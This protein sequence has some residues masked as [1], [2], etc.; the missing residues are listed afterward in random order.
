MASTQL[1]GDFHLDPADR[2][3]VA[4]ARRDGISLVTCDTKIIDYFHVQTIW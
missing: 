1:P 3:I 4:I 2:I